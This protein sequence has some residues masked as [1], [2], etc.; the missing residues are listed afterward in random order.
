MRVN[1]F[2][3]ARKFSA[4]CS[5]QAH[6]IALRK[7]VLLRAKGNIP[8][9]LPVQGSAG[10]S[11]SLLPKILGFV[12]LVFAISGAIMVNSK[13]LLYGQQPDTNEERIGV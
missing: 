5:S 6:S 11:T 8:A 1:F 2:I 10:K 13:K 9:S 12:M 4:G 7:R 3:A